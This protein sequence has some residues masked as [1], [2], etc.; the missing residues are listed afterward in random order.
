[1]IHGREARF[2]RLWQH[3]GL[4]TVDIHLDHDKI[5]RQGVSKATRESWLKLLQYA[6]CSQGYDGARTLHPLQEAR[7]RVVV[8]HP[9]A[10][11]LKLCNRGLGLAH[12]VLGSD[13]RMELD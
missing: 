11:S 7:W 8:W 12:I 3:L 2:H 6:G 1:M 10:F 4:A 13:L 9:D 5:M